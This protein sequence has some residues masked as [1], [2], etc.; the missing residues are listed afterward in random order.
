MKEHMTTCPTGN[1]AHYCLKI[2][3][4]F[5]YLLSL[6][7]LLN[8]SVKVI[9][10]KVLFIPTRKDLSFVLQNTFKLYAINTNPQYKS[11]RILIDIS[12]I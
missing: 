3:T 6:L 2:K 8:I 5:Y 9:L 4:F 10:C 11:L 1:T 7:Y 12:L